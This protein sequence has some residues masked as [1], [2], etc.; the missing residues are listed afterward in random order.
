LSENLITLQNVISHVFYQQHWRNKRLRQTQPQT[1]MTAPEH[2]PAI[3]NR[4]LAIDPGKISPEMLICYGAT[5]FLS[6]FL[7]FSIQPMA[8]KM[9]L[10]LYGG[11]PAVWNACMVFFQA[12]L[13][14]GYGYAHLAVKKLGL[15]RQPR[16]HL[17]L[18]LLGLIAL[19][20]ALRE[21]GLRR[22]PTRPRGTPI[23]CTPSATWAA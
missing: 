4:N 3:L 21:H 15:D 14:C 19:P 9:L 2:G 10:P 18:M 16:L 11:T 12:A 6:A 20:P 22:P 17:L 23:F 5:L 13:L 1:G 8:G 7:L